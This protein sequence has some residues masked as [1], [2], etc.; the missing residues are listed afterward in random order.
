MP[1]VDTFKTRTTLPGAGRELSMFSLRALEAAGFA[2]IATLPY[3]LKILLEN[4]LRHEDGRFVKAADVE[5]LARWD[6]KRSGAK[7]DRV[8]ARARAA[9]GFHRRAGGRRSRCDARRHRAARRGPRTASTRCSLSSSSSI[10]RCR[11]TTSAGR[12]RFS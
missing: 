1:T 11:S 10:I 5:A 7:G 9:P 8:H 3:S 4:L 6:V 12:T 2:T